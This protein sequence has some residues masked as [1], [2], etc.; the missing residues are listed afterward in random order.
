M[1]VSYGWLKHFLPTIPPIE[2]TVSILTSI[3]L[4]VDGY[5]R[6]GGLPEGGAG[7]VVGHV[8]SCEQHPNADRLHVTK[9]DVGGAE[10]LSIVCGAPNVAQGQ[11][12]VVATVGATLHPLQ[13]ESFKIK[14]AKLRGELSEGMLCAEDEIGLSPAHDGI[15]VLPEGIKPGTPAQQAIGGE[16]DWLIEIGL[17]ANRADAMSHHGVARDL[18]AYLKLHGKPGVDYNLTLPDMTLPTTPQPS[19]S[20]PTAQHPITLGN[21]DP[22]RCIRYCGLTIEG[23]KNGA[24]PHWL[25]NALASVGVHSINAVVDVT[26]YVLFALGQPLHAFDAEA[27]SGGNVSVRCLPQGTKLVTLDGKERTLDATDLIICNGEEPLC[28]AGVLGGANSGV[29]TG[30][31][32]IFLEAAVFDGVS[33]R[34]T[35]RRH[36]LNTEASFR[37]E[38][39]IDPAFTP[40]A[41]AYAARL[42]VEI[43]GGHIVGTPS[44]HYPTPWLPR[45]FNVNVAE[46][47]GRMGLSMDEKEIGRVLGFLE[48]EHTPVKPGVLH[49][50][51]P[52]YRVDVV[53][54]EDIAEELLRMVGYDAVPIPERVHFTYPLEANNRAV[55]LEHDTVQRLAGMGFHEIKA[56]SLTSGTLCDAVACF[57]KGNR[58]ELLNPLSA[59]LNT[60][61]PSLVFGIL[62]AIAR[63]SARQ[64]EDMMLFELGN[65]FSR[66]ATGKAPGGVKGY[67][68]RTAIALAVVGETHPEHWSGKAGKHSIFT[69][70]GYVSALLKMAG[71]QGNRLEYAPAPEGLYSAGTT[72]LEGERTLGHFG[73]L[74]PELTRRVEVKKSV[75]YA[76]LW[77]DILLERMLPGTYKYESVPRFPAV[78][79]D[80][81]LL[82]KAE[83]TYR[84]LERIAFRVEPKLLVEMNL[85][86]VYEGE[87]IPGGMKSYAVSFILQ[88]RE[89]TLQE[90]KIDGVMARLLLAFEQ[91][92]GAQQ[93]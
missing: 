16:E 44:D 71:I 52:R 32:R 24:S 29:T 72:L 38:R 26:N 2:E 87:G 73:E 17:T 56:L 79:R 22:E 34:K 92:L 64:Q 30:S 66:D 4:E 70:K 33:V 82:V 88:D 12:V 3:G 7:L 48:I 61:R 80:M 90:K 76:E 86:D 43:C 28:L 27:F 55:C 68:E 59:D 84:D 8:L 46:L 49:L 63:N 60:L 53:A 77:W 20:N 40:T 35:A 54:Q 78:R 31:K 18:S 36:G 9:V 74:N 47:C 6:Q 41:L 51:V 45:E 67:Q 89:G 23:V 93:R 19:C 37:F 58:V 69:L 15:M 42:I 81:A 10:P 11:N 85:F 62:D 65:L 50:S 75:Y 21:I 14:R 5:T 83:V 91:K 1:K 39:G 57:P 13:G 25:V